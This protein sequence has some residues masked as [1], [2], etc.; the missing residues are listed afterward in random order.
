MTASVGGTLLRV[1][2]GFYSLA[3]R[4]NLV[5]YWSDETTRADAAGVGWLAVPNLGG[6]RPV[7]PK[8]PPFLSHVAV[9][10]VLSHIIMSVTRA[11]QLAMSMRSTAQ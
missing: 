5:E 9:C 6:L 8:T 3:S 7:S 10:H 1:N 4:K 2:Q 11:T